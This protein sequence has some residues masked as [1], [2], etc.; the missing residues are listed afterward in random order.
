MRLG[1]S[2]ARRRG[3]R[4][5]GKRPPKT[6]PKSKKSKGTSQRSGSRLLLALAALA[7]LGWSGGYV[8][9]TQL[10]FPLPPPP[11]DLCAVP[12]FRG[13]GWAS[14]RERLAGAGLKLGEVDSLL[15]P[16]IALALIVGQSP[17]PGQVATP[18]SPVRVTVSRGPQMRSVPD[19]TRLDE[20][21]ARIVLESSGFVVAIDTAEAELPRGLVV[22][23]F[24]PADTIVALPTE[25]RV[26]I[27]TGPPLIAMP[28]VLGLGQEEAVQLLDSL[29]LVVSDVQE[30]FRF[31]RDQGIVVE[32]EPGADAEVVRGSEVQLSVGRRGPQT[33]H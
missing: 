15:H 14:A 13:V 32:Q 31:G 10:L 19:V 9:S 21:R 8:L 26:V 17:L 16:S 5:K 7:I 6:P 2:L 11:G 23:I 4:G 22:E 28:L 29:G 20:D 30:V 25:I 18:E 24:P 1:G 12:D 27:S 33:E 3:G